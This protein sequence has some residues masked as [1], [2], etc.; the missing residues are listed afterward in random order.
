MCGA[1]C[2][3]NDS[4]AS[5]REK[6]VLRTGPGPRLHH[7]LGWSVVGHARLAA[8]GRHSLHEL[9]C[10]LGPAVPIGLTSSAGAWCLAIGNVWPG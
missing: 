8:G 6:P 1:L 3:K 4:E 5:S 2:I 10:S 9:S 7:R